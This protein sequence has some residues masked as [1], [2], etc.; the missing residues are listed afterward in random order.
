MRLRS[1]ADGHETGAGLAF[2]VGC[3]RSGTSVVGELLASHPDVSYAWESHRVWNYVV[4]P[5]KHDRLTAEAASPR[6]ARRVRR[7][8]QERAGQERP[9]L[10]E[11][12]PRNTLR[13]P[14]V[15]A[16][17]PDAR[18]VHVVRDGRDVACSLVPGVGGNEWNHLRPPSWRRLLAD[19]SGAV[20]CGLAW[21]EILEI[22]LADLESVSHLQ[23]RYE[24]LVGDPIATSR[25][26]L[27]H[28]ELAPSAEVADYATRI[29]NETAGS[30][31]AGRQDRWSRDDH[32]V[33][34]G[35]WRE[36]LSAEEQRVLNDSLGPLLDRLGYR[37]R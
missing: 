28:L 6:A 5:G 15:K 36:N 7:G 18:I 20:R 2:V 31:Q 16:L 29:Q 33:R 37:R 14:F 11:K 12:N 24:D 1:H 32:R 21:K 10:V 22:A 19:H 4:R 8:L 26:L 35:R 3:A 23:I 27:G 13:I 17:F 9:L 25:A 30:Y 34:V